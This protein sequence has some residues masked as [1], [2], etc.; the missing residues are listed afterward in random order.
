MYLTKEEYR[1][2]KSEVKILITIDYFEV[3]NESLH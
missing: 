2:G 1:V 3:R